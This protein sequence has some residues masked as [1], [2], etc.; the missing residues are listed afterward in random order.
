MR[1]VNLCIIMGAGGTLLIHIDSVHN[2][3]LMH[4]TVGKRSSAIKRD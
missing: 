3:V 4:V 1:M 2:K